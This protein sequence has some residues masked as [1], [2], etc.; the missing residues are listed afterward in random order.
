M[1]SQLFRTKI[2]TEFAPSD[3]KRC[4]GPVHLIL[5]GIGA[6]IGTGIFV[7]TGLAAAQYAGPAIV[8]SFVVAGAGCLFSAL[9]YAEFAA[10]VPVSGSAYSY[11]YATLGEFIAWF[12]GWNLVLEY[13]FAA[14]TVSVGW[15]RYFVKLLD[16]FNI[17][18][19][20]AA[21]TTSPLEVT[22]HGMTFAFTGALIN[23]PAV[24]IAAVITAICYVGITQSTLV[25][26]IVVAIKVSIVVLVIGF[27]VFYVNADYWTPFI[28]ENT[29]TFG[30]YGISG[31]LRA[32]GVIFFAY[33][34]FD[35]VSTATLEAKNPARDMPIGILG[36]L[37]ICTILYILM[38]GVLTGMVH[39]PDLNDAAPV[40]VA[41][42]A[43]AGLHWLVPW[44]VVGALAGLTSVI[45]VMILGQA[46]IFLSMSRD[47]LLPPVFGAVHPEYRTPHMATLITGTLAALIGGVFPI[48]L[49]GELV[50]IGTLIAFIVV[51]I[52]V[53]VLRYTRPDLK[54][55]FR[56]PA[57]WVT[58]LLGVAF[59]GVMAVFLPADTWIR[60]LVWTVIGV[61]LYFFYG[62]RHSAL[63]QR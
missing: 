52:G 14:S 47:G 57:V 56:A 4:L 42:Q 10:M 43:H 45:L 27:G 46:R 1:A 41:L 5:L 30:E 8:L 44:V 6:I 12:V 3:L 28:P 25:N 29:G 55:P 19:L 7:L 2:V 18:F 21:L 36:S 33:I 50:S 62:Y 48:G 49:L 24:L 54:R 38:S 20:P 37:V 31:M 63:H 13:L 9:C 34:G 61:M 59:C 51:C 58:S 35:A 53:L 26:S 60:L 16:H 39:Y 32:A 15:S 22:N 17:N 23:L 40:A 11:S